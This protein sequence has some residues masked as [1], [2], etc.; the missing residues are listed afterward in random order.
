MKIPA[1]KINI[2]KIKAWSCAAIAC[3]YIFCKYFLSN[4]MGYM[5]LVLLLLLFSYRTRFRLTIRRSHAPVI[6]CSLLFG[7]YLVLSTT[8]TIATHTTFAT[9]VLTFVTIL[10]GL[11][12]LD[13]REFFK[14]L[15]T[16][17]LICSVIEM[18]GIFMPLFSPALYFH[19][20]SRLPGDTYVAAVG[21]LAHGRLCGFNPQTAYAGFFMSIGIA[22][23][24]NELVFRSHKGWIRVFY[25]LLLLLEV[26][27]LV[28]TFKRG[29][30]LCVVFSSIFVLFYNKKVSIVSALKYGLVIIV[31]GVTAVQL[32]RNIPEV[33]E[34][35]EQSMERF[36]QKDG[37]DMTSGRGK[38]NDRAIYLFEQNPLLGIGYGGFGVDSELGNHN[39]Y[40]EVLCECGLVGVVLYVA[41]LAVNL[42]KILI[43]V[44]KKNGDLMLLNLSLFYQLFY[45][46]HSAVENCLTDNFVFLTYMLMASLPYAVETKKPAYAKSNLSRVLLPC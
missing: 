42:L 38:L 22:V 32:L 10:I 18:V 26:V 13:Q 19:I 5:L 3:L 31:L 45:I 12:A 7:V 46:V 8:W 40:L 33:D 39:V 2:G 9:S 16:A 28:M 15:P 27:A 1:L 35:I 14:I 4:G 29:P 24:F 44:R 30:M 37:Q 11:S 41:F 20:L 43:S 21:F 25:L 6:A 23:L 34:S 36:E 17:I